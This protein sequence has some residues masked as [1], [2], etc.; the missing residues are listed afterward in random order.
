MLTCVD[1]SYPLQELNASQKSRHP[2]ND[3]NGKQLGQRILPLDG[4]QAGY[5]HI[6]LRTESNLTM[7]LATLFLHIVIKTYFP[8]ELS[9]K[10][11]LKRIQQFRSDRG[12]VSP[13]SLNSAPGNLPLLVNVDDPFRFGNERSIEMFDL[14]EMSYGIQ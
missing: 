13:G 1:K 12:P 4:L 14:V 7:I 11:S 3:K 8:D 6:T 5:R 2:L 9:G 10:F